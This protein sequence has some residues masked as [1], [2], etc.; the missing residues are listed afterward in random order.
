MTDGDLS[1]LHQGEAQDSHRHKAEGKVTQS[2]DLKMANIVASDFNGWNSPRDQ[3]GGKCLGQD[4]PGF[5]VFNVTICLQQHAPLLVVGC[6][7]TRSRHNPGQRNHGNRAQVSVIIS[8]RMCQVPSLMT[9]EAGVG[10]LR[11]S[12]VGGQWP[13]TLPSADVKP[14][15]N[16]HQP[17]LFVGLFDG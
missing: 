17:S 16:I 4:V 2:R 11:L 15:I 1:L 8:V 6:F 13:P 14:A 7:T 5:Q 9:V 3:E 10:T 12:P